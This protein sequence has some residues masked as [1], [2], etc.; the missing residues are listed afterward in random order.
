MEEIKEGAINRINAI[1]AVYKPRLREL[2]IEEK[3]ILKEFEK[4]L[5]ILDNQN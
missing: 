4:C 1:I 3:R 2:T 5:T